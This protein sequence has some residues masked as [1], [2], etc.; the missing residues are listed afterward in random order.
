M[1]VIIYMPLGAGIDKPLCAIGK[2]AKTQRAS[3]ENNQRPLHDFS[4]VSS[5]TLPL[6]L[7]IS[8][9]GLHSSMPLFRNYC[10]SYGLTNLN[11]LLPSATTTTKS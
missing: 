4:K 11:R 5:N 3:C 8:R 10:N 9:N 7:K 2:Y 1:C 6:I